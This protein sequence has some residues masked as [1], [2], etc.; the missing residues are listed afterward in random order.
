[1]LFDCFPDG[2]NVLGGAPFNV[3]WNLQGLGHEPTLV[4]AVGRDDPGEVVR[5]KMAGWGLS[6]EGLQVSERWPTGT[7]QVKLQDGQPAFEILADQAYDDIGFPGFPVSPDRFSLLYFGSL[8]YRSEVSRKTIQHLMQESQLPRFVDINI[9]QPWFDMEWIPQLLD[10]SR[11]IKLND[12]ELSYITGMPSKTETEIK[13][14]VNQLHSEHGGEHYFITCGA[15][16]AYAFNFSKTASHVF[17]EAPKPEPLLDAVGAGDALTAAMIH[18][19]SQNQAL[20]KVLDFAVR[21]ASR[22]CTIRGA[23]TENREFYQQETDSA[24]KYN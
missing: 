19:I 3:A 13:T 18:G 17:A 2:R 12:A 5:C 10:G 8:A 20:D 22:I 7:V 21:F 1:V 9:R 15:T 11:W 24:D 6:T 23:T 16:G 4:T 14:A